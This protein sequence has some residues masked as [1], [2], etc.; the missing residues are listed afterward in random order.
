[1]LTLLLLAVEFNLSL[2][3]FVY[4]SSLLTVVST[5]CSLL[6]GPILTSFV[7][8][9]S[10]SMSTF[11]C[12]VLCIVI[13]F[14][15]VRLICLSS[16]SVHFEKGPEYLTRRISLIRFLLQSSVLRIFF[17]SKV[18]LSYF[19]FH[20][21][22]DSVHFQYSQIFV[23][24][25]SSKCSEAFL[26]W[27]FFSFCCFSSLLFHYQHDTFFHDKFYN[28]IL[29]VY[30]YSLYKGFLFFI[31]GKYLSII[32]IHNVVYVFLRLWKCVISCA[33]LKQI[34]K[35]HHCF[36]IIAARVSLPVKCLFR[37]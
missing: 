27:L 21:M 5:H 37:F 30:S 8:T 28:Y 17:S 9:Y 3:C 32:H 7:D 36:K 10:L 33:F 14:L 1:M 11:E 24:F 35:R 4:F 6:V 2:H 19:F 15:V 29:A 31:L 26:I 34:S 18:L 12:K 16:F 23:I 13:N 25:F 20:L 22:F